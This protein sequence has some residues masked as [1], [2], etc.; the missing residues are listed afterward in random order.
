[1]FHPSFT[2]TSRRWCHSSNGPGNWVLSFANGPFGFSFSFLSHERRRKKGVRAD[3]KAR[4][5][6]EREREREREQPA[7]PFWG[8][9][10][11]FPPLREWMAALAALKG[12]TFFMQ[13]IS[14]SGKCPISN[15]KKKWASFTCKTWEQKWWSKSSCHRNFKKWSSARFRENRVTKIIPNSHANEPLLL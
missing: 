4:K 5:E 2:F 14:Y 6:R 12:F 10:K 7:N 11:C 3:C 1:M 15:D 9:K 8:G 13:K